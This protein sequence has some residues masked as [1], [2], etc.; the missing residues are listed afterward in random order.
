MKNSLTRLK[1]LNDKG[2]TEIICIKQITLGKKQ[3]KS[4]YICMFLITSLFYCQ[5]QKTIKSW[6][7]VIEICKSTCTQGVVHIRYRIH[8]RQFY[9][10]TVFSFEKKVSSSEIIF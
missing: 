4:N 7:L 6:I 3:K 2:V 9:H 1:H 8:I 5:A 10:L